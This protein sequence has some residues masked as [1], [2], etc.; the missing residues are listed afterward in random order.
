[1][2]D[3]DLEA[4]LAARK[5]QRARERDR[6]ARAMRSE[7]LQVLEM[8]LNNLRS[9]IG[10]VSSSTRAGAGGGTPPNPRWESLGARRHSGDR[11]P[12]LNSSAI[13]RGGPPGTPAPGH[14][15]PPPPPPLGGLRDPNDDDGEAPI[16][17][18]VQKREKAE[19]QRRREAKRKER[20]AAK[21]PMTLAEIIKSAG[22]NPSSRL[23]PKGAIATTDVGGGEEPVAEMVAVTLK[24]P[25]DAKPKE[26]KKEPTELEAALQKVSSE[27]NKEGPVEDKKEE[28][29]GK[30][31]GAVKPEEGGKAEVKADKEVK[32]EKEDVNEAV[33]KK[34]KDTKDDAASK[35]EKPVEKTKVKKTEEGNSDA[36][37]SADKKETDTEPLKDRKAEEKEGEQQKNEKGKVGE[38]KED[39]QKS[40]DEKEVKKA[41][42]EPEADLEKEEGTKTKGTRTLE[43][44]AGGAK[45]EGAKK[46]L[47]MAL[48]MKK[49]K[50]SNTDSTSAAAGVA[51]GAGGENKA[52]AT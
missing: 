19:R 52:T 9:K 22:K 10:S 41:K 17:P 29:E 43:K 12:S 40:G 38:G 48:L 8:E 31:E 50:T 49:M 6:Y 35:D 13:K 26:K 33:E 51:G 25:E 5:Q 14:T 4:E 21:K 39:A 24:K 34:E 28:N 32:A 30:A 23:K 1:M 16:D 36:Q 45:A 18:E 15:G 20:E 27:S 3:A 47:D 42:E 11:A 37:K 46:G 44:E 2:S 7:K